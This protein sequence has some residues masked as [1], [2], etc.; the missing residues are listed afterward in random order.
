MECHAFR[1]NRVVTSLDQ[2]DQTRL[3]WRALFGLEGPSLR[4]RTLRRASDDHFG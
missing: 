1:E 4:K 3:Q 2:G